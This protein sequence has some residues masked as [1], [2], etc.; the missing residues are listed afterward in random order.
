MPRT[1]RRRSR[2]PAG[3]A[4]LAGVAAVLALTACM[5]ELPTHPTT[6]GTVAVS[7]ATA[8]AASVQP[9]VP[10]PTSLASATSPTSAA[11]LGQTV[12][13][14]DVSSYQSRVDWPGLWASGHR[15]AWVKATEGVTYV[16]P[17][18]AA[19]RSGALAVGMLVGGYHYARP[20]S[21]GGAAQARH[22]LAH[23]GGWTPDGRTLPGA[24]DLEPATTTDPC[25]GLTVPEFVGWV[26]DFVRTYR[27][28]IGRPPVIYVATAMWQRCLG[29][30][31]SVGADSP[32]WLFDHDGP[33][34]PLPARWNRPT[35]WQRGVENN[36]DR[37]VFLGGEAELRRWAT[38]P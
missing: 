4:G 21:S 14:V 29:D 31:T 6:R 18:Y 24:L 35:V 5:P 26:E 7:S 2:Q 11:S 23:G 19:Q 25:H 32:L 37:N 27:A 36:L 16:S 28:A 20:A 15:F 13:G 9:P 17:T 30:N 8:A 33:M 12:A 1:P 3:A 34:G 38:T 10:S 22:F